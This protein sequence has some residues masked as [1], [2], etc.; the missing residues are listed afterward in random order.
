MI[1]RE[2]CFEITPE[3]PF[4]IKDSSGAELPNAYMFITRIWNKGTEAVLGHEL[5]DD[6]PLS[7]LIEESARVLAAPVIVKP[8]RM[9]K[10]DVTATAPNNFRC[11][12][13]CLNPGECG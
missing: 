2:R 3:M 6:H 10:F 4:V 1:G 8:S 5:S 13:D 11:V 9:M 12:F 7:I